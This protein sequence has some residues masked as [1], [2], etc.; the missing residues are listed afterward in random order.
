MTTD[1]IQGQKGYGHLVTVASIA[2]L[3]GSVRLSDYCA[4][5]FAAVGLEE[6]LR[7]E[8]QCDGYTGIH[9]T[10]V[11]PFFIST[12]MFAGVDSRYQ[13]LIRRSNK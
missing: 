6:A 13:L 1:K 12:G 11:C 4:S 2:G 7:L 9:S 3:T 10:V 8:L 5:K